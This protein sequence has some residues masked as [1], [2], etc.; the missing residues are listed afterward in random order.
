MPRLKERHYQ[1]RVMLAMAAYV[2]AM[3]LVWPLVRT[4]SN[5]PLRW[6]L[7]LAPLPPMLYVIGLMAQRIRRSD[8]LEQRTHLIGLGVAT[9]VVATLSLAAGFLASAQ[10]LALDGSILI[11]VFPVLMASYGLTRWWVAQQY[12]DDRSCASDDGIALHWRLAVATVLMACVAL[13][14]Y[15]KRDALHVG[16]LAG[17][18]AAIVVLG[19]AR[20]VIHWRKRRA[21]REHGDA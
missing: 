11:W 15:L 10:L 19:V 1:Q 5:V 21:A 9:G 7:A 4:A 18:A 6:A 13:V 17:M 3:L 20:A 16:M 2:A 14:A 12:G 8:E